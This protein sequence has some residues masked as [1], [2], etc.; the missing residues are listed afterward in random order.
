MGLLRFGPPR[1]QPCQA[2]GRTQAWS[3]IDGMNRLVL[4]PRV[5]RPTQRAL[6]L[7]KEVAT[8]S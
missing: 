3:W 8:N 5:T 4:A 7:Q 1:K 2:V 6:A